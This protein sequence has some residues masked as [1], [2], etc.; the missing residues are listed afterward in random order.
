M[1]K[2]LIVITL[3]LFTTKIFPSPQ[4]NLMDLSYQSFV[5]TKDLENAYLIAKKA[6]KM[7]PQDLKWQN[8][9][10]Q[11]CMWTSR[12]EEAIKIYKK[13]YSIKKD[14]SIVEPYLSEIKRIDKD[15]YESILIEKIRDS[16]SEKELTLLF[17]FYIENGE[18]EK[19]YNLLSK[20]ENKIRDKKIFSEIAFFLLETGNVEKAISLYEK[21]LKPD[22]CFFYK[23]AG[24]LYFASKQNNKAIEI[25]STNLNKC[26]NEEEFPHLLADIALINGDFE[27][28]MKARNLAYK[29]GNYREIDAEILFKYYFPGQ[30]EI[31]RDI[32]LSAWKKFSKKYFFQLFLS[33]YQNPKEK[34]YNLKLFS[35]ESIYEQDFFNVYLE[36]F[37]LLSAK[38]KEILKEIAFKSED[39]NILSSYLWTLVS[40]GNFEERKK[41][42]LNF[43]CS[44]NKKTNSLLALAFLKMSVHMYRDAMACI[45]LYGRNF[46]NSP[47][48]LINYGDFL[49]NAGF[50]TEST[51]YKRLA[52]ESY[53][54]NPPFDLQNIANFLRLSMEF[55]DSYNYE[56]M[57]N[58]Y[59]DKISTNDYYD[60]YISFLI[61]KNLPEKT[62]YTIKNSSHKPDWARFYLFTNK[63]GEFEKNSVSGDNPELLSSFYLLNKNISYAIENLWKALENAPDSYV[64]QNAWRDISEKIYPLYNITGEYSYRDFAE[65]KEISAGFSKIISKKVKANVKI[66]S[67]D[68]NLLSKQDFSTKNINGSNIY[69]GLDGNNWSIYAGY[70]KKMKD[71]YPVKMEINLPFKNVNYKTSLSINNTSKDTFLLEISGMEN[72]LYQELNFKTGYG[73]FV[74]ANLLIYEYYDQNGLYLGK[75]LKEEISFFKK[76][77]FFSLRPY[78]KQA[79]YSK[80]PYS[81]K[82]LAYKISSYNPVLILPENFK[83][84]GLS[85][86]L[87]EKNRPRKTRW[88]FPLNLNISYN[89]STKMY[90]SANVRLIKEIRKKGDISIDIGYSKANSTNK[91]SI[92]SCKALLNFR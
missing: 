32:A 75:G 7:Y 50:D 89:S 77:R 71:F 20:Y 48:F 47:H 92:F 10:A 24:W 66:S 30:K 72:S 13:L 6:T 59:K 76:M 15:F 23:R 49:Q 46:P 57:L 82:A 39:E 42:A 51:F 38:E 8:R 14:F 78:L 1:K 9:L 90:Y 67:W 41:A 26:L 25:L 58:S 56:E 52:Y 31:A 21:S 12:Q 17:S 40:S 35:P 55:S 22:E 16:Y 64:S 34:L 63:L 74:N 86:Y 43:S 54:R 44:L 91:D 29:S 18:K 2:K 36:N 53:L 84:A 28:E 11:V 62:A 45:T 60:L 79:S 68:M 5:Y 3:L 37:N 83:E 88:N 4:E 73:S 85:I 65:K 81:S 70:E 87:F 61:S 80:A 27:I 33:T 69:L 19:L